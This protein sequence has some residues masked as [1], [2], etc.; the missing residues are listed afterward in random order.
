MTSFS[1]FFRALVQSTWDESQSIYNNK[2]WEKVKTSFSQ[3]TNGFGLI[4][5]D[6]KILL[7]FNNLHSAPFKSPYRRAQTHTDEHTGLLSTHTK[8][9]AKNNIIKCDD[10]TKWKHQ[11]VVVVGTGGR[12]IK[13]HTITSETYGRDIN[14]TSV[15]VGEVSFTVQSSDRTLG[16]FCNS[17]LTLASVEAFSFQYRGKIC[18]SFSFCYILGTA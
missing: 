11:R 9:C 4:S 12:K 16:F 10:E 8:R 7:I 18:Y 5:S 3:S 13:L 1:C 15:I 2:S 6:R 14:D 17:S